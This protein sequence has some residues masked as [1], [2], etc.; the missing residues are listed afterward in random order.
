MSQAGDTA[1]QFLTV[2]ESQHDRRYRH[3][4]QNCST[5]L[6]FVWVCMSAAHLRNYLTA[7]AEILDG[8]KACP[9]HIFLQFGDDCRRC[10]SGEPKLLWLKF[11]T[12][13]RHVLDTFSC[14]LVTTAAG[15]HQGSQNC[16]NSASSWQPDKSFIGSLQWSALGHPR[17]PQFLPRG[18]D[19]VSLA[20]SYR[21]LIL[22]S[23]TQQLSDMRTMQTFITEVIR[24]HRLSSYHFTELYK[25]T[26]AIH[27]SKLANTTQRANPP[28]LGHGHNSEAQ[29]STILWEEMLCCCTDSRSY[30]N[31]VQTGTS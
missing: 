8:T 4:C 27:Q 20:L 21:Y 7:L 30:L 1:Q 24:Y 12:G 2:L 16:V 9:G 14:S 10:P 11:W 5:S 25:S 23:L 17:R 15:V 18:D 29:L 31:K 6:L 26:W 13:Q 22:F 3:R 28:S 19:C